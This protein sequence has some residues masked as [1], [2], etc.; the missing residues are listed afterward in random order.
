MIPRE[1]FVQLVDKSARAVWMS[2]NCSVLGD[3]MIRKQ[4]P[5]INTPLMG[6]TV[7]LLVQVPFQKD[8]DQYFGPLRCFL[9][10][11]TNGYDLYEG[12]EQYV[13][14]RDAHFAT[15]HAAPEK[16]VECGCGG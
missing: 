7:K 15:A 10:D 2:Y 13:G 6:P 12:N 14:G 16:G 9:H 5:R 11:P 4:L 1:V 8:H 3:L